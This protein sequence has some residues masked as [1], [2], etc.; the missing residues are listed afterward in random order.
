VSGSTCAASAFLDAPG[1]AAVPLRLCCALAIVA[2]A[3]S[4]PRSVVC[5]SDQELA[6]ILGGSAAAEADL[7]WPEAES[8]AP[9]I[10]EA[11]RVAE[12]AGR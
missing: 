6:S 7:R 1:P 2:A 12:E 11:A 9:A 5:G 4:T 10:G 8:T 3:G